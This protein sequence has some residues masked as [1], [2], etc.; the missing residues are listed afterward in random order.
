[1]DILQTNINAESPSVAYDAAFN[2]TLSLKFSYRDDDDRYVLLTVTIPAKD[3]PSLM[4]NVA[5]AGGNLLEDIA[6]SWAYGDCDTCGNARLVDAPAPG[7]R[8]Q[9]VNCPACRGD[10]DRNGLASFPTVRR[11]GASSENREA[12]L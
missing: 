11:P 4:R 10:S 6:T 9:S 7:G 1:M 5:N 3:V 12:T 2:G 8:T